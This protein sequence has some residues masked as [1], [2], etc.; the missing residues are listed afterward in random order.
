MY[1]T[2]E[3]WNEIVEATKAGIARWSAQ[4]AKHKFD[5]RFAVEVQEAGEFT[6]LLTN[7]KTEW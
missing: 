7:H 2:D 1:V 3:K 4:V 5:D 6:V